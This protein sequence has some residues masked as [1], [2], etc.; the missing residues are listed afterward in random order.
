[1]KSMVIT[2]AILLLGNT[3][4]SDDVM[5]TCKIVEE[6]AEAAMKNRQRGVRMSRQMEIVDDS[7]IGDEYKSMFR[8]LI[9]DAYQIPRYEGEDYQNPVINDFTD[10]IFKECYTIFKEA[11]E[12]AQNKK[13][14]I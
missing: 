10:T 5:D 11:Q 4:Y 3:A 9:I 2:L 12:K 1:M 14:A 7:E 8:A 13:L 6:F